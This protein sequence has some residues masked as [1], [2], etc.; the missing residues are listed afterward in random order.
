MFIQQWINIEKII[1]HVFFIYAMA[2][3]YLQL[4]LQYFS[5][6]TFGYQIMKLHCVFKIM[7]SILKCVPASSLVFYQ[8]GYKTAMKVWANTNV[9]TQKMKY[10]ML[11]DGTVMKFDLSVLSFYRFSHF[12]QRLVKKKGF[13][14]PIYYPAF[15]NPL[16]GPTL[17][18]H[19]LSCKNSTR[20]THPPGVGAGYMGQLI[21]D[22]T[23]LSI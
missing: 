10:V 8:L 14:V 7:S 4:F 18:T 21:Q 3:Q 11:P 2:S 15:L 12:L 22:N 1:P 23:T 16:T 9:D 13:L 6:S 19:I 20:D 5:N 17:S